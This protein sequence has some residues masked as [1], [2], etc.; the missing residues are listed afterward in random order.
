MINIVFLYLVAGRVLDPHLRPLSLCFSLCVCAFYMS[1]AVTSLTRVSFYLSLCTRTQTAV[2]SG[3]L[4]KF[5]NLLNS[6]CFFMLGL[7]REYNDL[8]S[9]ISEYLGDHSH[10]QEPK[11]AG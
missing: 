4:I 7:L 8:R 9:F 5:T 10:S 1:S 11:L 2:C 6:C 3:G